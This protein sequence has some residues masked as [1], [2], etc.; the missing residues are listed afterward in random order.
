VLS[1]KI[2][3]GILNIPC[4]VCCFA[5]ARERRRGRE[6]RRG[7][8]RKGKGK[9]GRREERKGKKREK[10]EGRTELSCA[11]PRPRTGRRRAA[12]RASLCPGLGRKFL[13]CVP[14]Y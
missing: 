14:P 12:K 2:F 1:L 10:R 13:G 5:E 8:E 3:K 11:P 4:F 9:R 6:E 7:E